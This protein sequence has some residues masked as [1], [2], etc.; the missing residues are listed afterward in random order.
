[1]GTEFLFGLLLARGL[2]W[3]AI[4]VWVVA[5]AGRSAAYVPH[6]RV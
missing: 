3:T 4:W 2:P 1:M 6:P 5:G